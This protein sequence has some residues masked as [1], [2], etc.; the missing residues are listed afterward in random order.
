[1]A[2]GNFKADHVQQKEPREPD[3]WLSDG[4]GM[5]PNKEKYFEFLKHAFEMLTV[6]HCH[7]WWL[8]VAAALVMFRPLMS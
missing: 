5:Q 7:L 6:S 3:V 4:S 2:D 8:S 1:M